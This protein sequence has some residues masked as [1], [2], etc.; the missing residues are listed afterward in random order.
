MSDLIINR[1]EV[2]TSLGAGFGTLALRGM[3]GLEASA[4][5]SRRNNPLA[6]RPPHFAAK[7]KSVIFLFMYGGPSHIDLFDPKPELTKWHGEPIPVFK[8]EDVFR[9]G[10]KN[11]A[12]ASPFKFTK[13]GRAA[14]D[15]CEQFPH[16]ARQA[17]ELCVIRSMHAE[18]N[19]HGPALF[20]MQTG[21]TL[22]GRPS[23]GSWVTYGLGTENENL[24]A[25]VV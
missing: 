13:Y 21:A 20:Q 14:I 19:N 3:M 16:L 17:D 24:P 1:R 12:F 15:I 6:V 4:A 10:S 9:K 18:S 25:Y 2:L 8:Q 11:S 5:E 7:A 23:I 22:T